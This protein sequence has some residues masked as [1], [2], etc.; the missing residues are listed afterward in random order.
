[1]HYILLLICITE[2]I[3]LLNAKEIKMSH[4]GY[5]YLDLVEE[6]LRKEKCE[7]TI[8]MIW[9]YALKMKLDKKLASVGKTPANTLN[10]SIRRHIANASHVRFKQTSKKPAKY[11]LNN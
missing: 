11:Y 7:M 3:P 10:A 4:K 6:V 1:M 5:T 9:K 2:V 8:P